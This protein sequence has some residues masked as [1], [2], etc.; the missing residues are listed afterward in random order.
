MNSTFGAR[1][2]SQRERQQI[3]L[4]TIAE[5]TKIKA[6]LLEALERDD[7][8]HWPHGIFGRSYIRSYAQAIGLDPDTTLREFAEC[9]AVEPSPAELAELREK[10][11]DRS[12]T[13]R[14]P[15][16]L[17]FLIDSAIDAFHTRRAELNHKHESPDAK[18]AS[19]VPVGFA[20]A[21][22]P[23]MAT[24]ATPAVDFLGLARLCAKLACAQHV[25]ELTSV[26]EDAS[27]VLD[28]AGLILWIPD[29][30]GVALIP[31]FAHGYPDEM[32]AQLPGVSMD[33]H[34][35]IAEAFQTRSTCVVNGTDTE[36]G[37]VVAP[38]LTPTTCGGVLSLEF[39]DGAEQR[40]EV[41]AGVMLLA[42]QV[43]TLVGY[44]VLAQTRSA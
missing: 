5:R 31:A 26:L 6:S 39:R 18:P 40:D 20:F 4:T 12:T 24:A 22:A 28:S 8:T 1:L 19:D 29:A 44:T 7:L 23:A 2:R 41:R 33:A 16:R 36:S 25:H 3:S 34:N 13:R 14:P 42:A 9:H 30:V 38:L 27:G 15:T 43:S 37:A 11:A 35:A 32:I 10:T 17:Q 21:P